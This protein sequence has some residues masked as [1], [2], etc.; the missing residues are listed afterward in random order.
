MLSASGPLVDASDVVRSRP[1][2]DS[3]V[4]AT[5]VVHSSMRLDATAAAT[6]MVP[7][8]NARPG[9]TVADEDAPMPTVVAPMPTRPRITIG[10]R[11]DDEHVPQPTVVARAPTG[12]GE[13][14]AAEEEPMAT[15]VGPVPLP[16]SL[17]R[18]DA[19]TAPSVATIDE[20]PG[21]IKPIH[22]VSVVGSLCLILVGMLLGWSARNDDPQEQPPMA[23][24]PRKVVAAPTPTPRPVPV[25]VPAAEKK[26]VA[27]PTPIVEE[28]SVAA[29]EAP[30]AVARPRKKVALTADS[31]NVGKGTLK[32]DAYPWARVSERGKEIGVT[33]LKLELSAGEHQ[34]VLEN[35]V[36]KVRRVV[37]L[38]IKSKQQ[39]EHVEKLAP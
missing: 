21:G 11:P 26:V 9:E 25:P 18:R 14:A 5:V 33:P 4:V 35:A 20:G 29:D 16:A 24:Q 15:R 32:L 8:A 36:L 13:T 2:I 23:P 19:V 10:E 30:K 6:A 37:K 22:V 17:S 39:L 7:A 12:P 34:F 1:A 38:T 27:V 28:P 3:G 31:S